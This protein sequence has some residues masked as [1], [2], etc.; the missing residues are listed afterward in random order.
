[1]KVKHSCQVLE[2]GMRDIKQAKWGWIRAG[3]LGGVLSH[4]TGV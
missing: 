4:P 2:I 3:S 1:M